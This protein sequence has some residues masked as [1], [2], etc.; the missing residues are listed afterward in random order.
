MIVSVT[1]KYPTLGKI[2]GEDMSFLT[3]VL[4]Q[5]FSRDRKE[6]LVDE[7]EQSEESSIQV[8]VKTDIEFVHYQRLVQEMQPIKDVAELFSALSMIN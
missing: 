8:E 7:Q 5:E 3:S 6:Y 4:E 1:S 2:F